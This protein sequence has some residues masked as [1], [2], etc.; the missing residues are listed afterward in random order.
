MPALRSF[1]PPHDHPPASLAH[2]ALAVSDY[3]RLT[4]REQAAETIKFGRRPGTSTSLP[5]A[6]EARC[7]EKVMSVS[8]AKTKRERAFVLLLNHD[9]P[10]G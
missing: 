7:G 1:R 6:K 3:R 2:N 5:H 9:I 4:E 10:C 8:R